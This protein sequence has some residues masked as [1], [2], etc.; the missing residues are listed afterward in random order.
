MRRTLATSIVFVLLASVFVVAIG[1]TSIATPVAIDEATY[2]AYGRVFPDPHGCVRGLPT[3]SPWAKGNV[4]AAQFIQWDEAI[5]GLGFL[6][7]R[8]PR[9]MQLID[10]RTQMGDHPGFTDLDLRSAGLPRV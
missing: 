7:D 9:F 1:T 5:G 6:E 8:F 10:L 2:T 4:C 3:K